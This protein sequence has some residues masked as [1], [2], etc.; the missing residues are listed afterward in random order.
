L[1]GSNS[2]DLRVR[3]GSISSSYQIHLA[4]KIKN[5]WNICCFLIIINQTR[6]FDI[7]SGYMQQYAYKS[8]QQR[9]A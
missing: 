4:E 7:P 1:N 6:D 2:S 3:G 8:L 9:I 5:E